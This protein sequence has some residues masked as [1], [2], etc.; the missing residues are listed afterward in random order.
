VST[1]AKKGKRR[2]HAFYCR[3]VI[4]FGIVPISCLLPHNNGMN[5]MILAT[6]FE[7]GR[8]CAKFSN[9][10]MTRGFSLAWQIELQL[11]HSVPPFLSIGTEALCSS[12]AA[13][14]ISSV[15]ATRASLLN[16]GVG[17]IAISNAAA[18]S[19]HL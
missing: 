2:I 17:E 1:S 10:P 12:Q 16:I 4:E 19:I 11:F 8:N 9:S 18:T 6:S 15:N 14:R 7:R 13:N 5:L 3:D